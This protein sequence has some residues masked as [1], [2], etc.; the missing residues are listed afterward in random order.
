MSATNLLQLL[1]L[2]AIWGASF[3]FMRI[4]VTDLGPVGLNTF[5]VGLAALFLYLVARIIRDQLPRPIPWRHFLI[6]GLVNT[7]LP[8]LLFA[9]AAQTLTASLLSIFNSTAPIWGALI[10]ALWTR[11]A[12]SPKTITGLLLGILGVYLLVGLDTQVSSGS[13]AWTAIAASLAA[14]FCYGLASNYARHAAPLSPFAN[15]HGSMWAATLMFIPLLPFFPATATPSGGI[16]L[17]VAALGVLCTGI[18]YLLYFRLVRDIGAAPALTVTYLIPMFGILWGVVFLDEAIGWHTLL[19][20]AVVLS[21]T[22]FVTG[23]SF[24]QLTRREVLEHD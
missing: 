14:P 19:G 3:L 22:A 2:S 10:A 12:M 1:I 13:L 5:R 18:A 21:G 8:F 11:E 23:F 4:A 15:A 6:L 7:A 24:R 20:T 17:A 9:Y 16:M